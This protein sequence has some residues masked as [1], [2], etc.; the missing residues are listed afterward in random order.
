MGCLAALSQFVSQLGECE[1]TLFKLLK[2]SDSFYWIDDT[3]K[4]LDDLMALIPKPP[5]LASL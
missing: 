3:Q 5:V 2:K 4:A 1:L